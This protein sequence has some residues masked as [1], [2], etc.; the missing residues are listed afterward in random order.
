MGIWDILFLVA[1]IVLVLGLAFYF[2]NKWASK[3]TSEQHDMVEQNKQTVSIYVI[4]KKK[5]KITNANLPK[6]MIDQVPRMGKL[7]KMPLVKVKVGPQIMTMVC[8]KAVYD[9]LPLK[10]TVSV[11]VAGAY[12]VG[13]KGMKT[14]REMAELRKSRRKGSDGNEPQGF[15]GKLLSRFRSK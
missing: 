14:K 13:M 5:D 2:L 12:I 6:A 4:D 9:A 8:D 11:E 3:K 15:G 7:M 10:K 1:I